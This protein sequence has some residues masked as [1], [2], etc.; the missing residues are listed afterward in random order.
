MDTKVITVLSF[1]IGIFMMLGIASAEDRTPASEERDPASAEERS[2][3]GEKKPPRVVYPEKTKLDFE[4]AAIEG[5]LRNP[6]E[7]YF[8]HKPEEKF[9]SLIKRRK[10]FHKEMLRDVVFS[11]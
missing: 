5:E 11:K 6:G 2:P 7:F 9:D 1:F 10:N 3:S 4:G 8:Q